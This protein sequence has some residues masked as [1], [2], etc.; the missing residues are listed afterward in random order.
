MS[1]ARLRMASRWGL[2]LVLLWGCSEAETAWRSNQP[3]ERPHASEQ[4][5]ERPELTL[6]TEDP[7]D[8][9]ILGLTP[10]QLERFALGDARFEQPFREAQGL[11]PLYIQRSCEACHEEDSRGPSVVRRLAVDAGVDRDSVLPHGDVI[12][13]RAIGSHQPLI[14]ADGAPVREEVRLGPPIFG[15][16]YLEAVADEQMLV[17]E[18][19]Q[20]GR[21]DGISGRVHRVARASEVPLPEWLPTLGRFGLKARIA[22]LDEFAADALRGDMGITSPLRPDEPPNPDGVTD[23]DRPGVD[24]DREAVALIADYVRL[25][26]IPDRPGLVEADLELLARARCTVCHVDR[27]RTRADHPVEAL[28]SADVALFTDLLLHDM[29]EGLADGIAEG[30]ASGREWQTPALMGLRF[31]RRLLHDGR[32]QTVAEAIDA[33][34]SPGSE[35]NDSI[36][37]FRALTEAERARLVR[38]VERL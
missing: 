21:D 8:G 32:A 19:E 20:A 38:Y 23:D 31:Q 34:A 27:V 12:R 10:A 6:V 35:A 15:R 36:E 24:L 3:G 13:P 26:A 11:G 22:S 18:R 2:A 33:H 4:A 7:S 16:G 14:P 37:R 9:P 25:V 29:G 5:P 30:D 17:W 1:V 28:A